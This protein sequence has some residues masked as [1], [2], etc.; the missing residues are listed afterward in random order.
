MDPGNAAPLAAP[1]DASAPL[2]AAAPATG[3]VARA[4][5]LALMTV[6]FVSV[7]VEFAWAHRSLSADL[8]IAP[9]AALVEGTA[10]TPFQYR[11]LVPWL[12]GSTMAVLG[13]SGRAVRSLSL[14]SEIA[15]F[16]LFLAASFAYL[17]R[18]LGEAGAAALAL[19]GAPLLVVQE[20]LGPN[21]WF[22]PYDTPAAALLVLALAAL[23][24]RRWAVYYA[25][26]AAATLN[27]ET[28]FI[29]T[30]TMLLA[31]R[32]ELD[33]RTLARHV[34]AQAAIWV[35]LK[36]GLAWIYRDN[37]GAGLFELHHVSGSGSH[38]ATNLKL[39]S[40]APGAALVLSVAAGLWAPL[41]VFGSRIEDPLLRWAPRVLVAYAVVLAFIGNLWET[42]MFAEFTGIAVCG[43]GA[44]LRRPS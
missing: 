41:L 11:A 44:L 4:A 12:I 39:L 10:R 33:R 16:L 5:G 20:L 38:L 2:A 14:A 1:D 18:T 26:F 24:A 43:V 35:A 9:V 37:A 30:G 31:L 36:L 7:A 3:S 27:R 40:G 21:R 15:F 34:A 13:L 32:S 22:M 29:L 19:L 17:R 6:V 8:P 42:R 23:S 28:T 25:I